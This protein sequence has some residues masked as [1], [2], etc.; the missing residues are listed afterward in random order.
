MGVL[1]LSISYLGIIDERGL[2]GKHILVVE[3]YLVV[4]SRTNYFF[5]EI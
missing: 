3:V 4:P 5:R 2:D 1:G